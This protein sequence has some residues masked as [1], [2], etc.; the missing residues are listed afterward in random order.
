MKRL[1]LFLIFIVAPLAGGGYW[2][3]EQGLLDDYLG[4]KTSTS[5]TYRTAPIDRGDL[6]KMIAVTGAINPVS[7]VT[8][9]PQVS[10]EVAEVFVDFNQRVEPKQP[11]AQLRQD[12]FRLRIQQARYQTK[13]SASDVA[14]R[15]AAV[16]SAHSDL[17][18]AEASLAGA[19]HTR[20]NAKRRWSVAETTY[21]RATQLLKAGVLAQ[22]EV[23]KAKAALDDADAEVKAAEVKHRV[24]STT[25]EAKSARIDQLNEEV[26]ASLSREQLSKAQ[27]AEQEYNLAHTEITAP[28]QGVILNR[29]IYKGDVVSGGQKASEM[30]LIAENLSSMQLEMD[31]DESD[32]GRITTG[33]RVRFTVDAYPGR[34][35]QGEITQKRLN[36]EVVQSVVTYKVIAKVDNSDQTLLPGMTASAEIITDSRS[37]VLRVSASA[38][39]FKP[40]QEKSKPTAEDSPN[41]TPAETSGSQPPSRGGGGEGG[42]GRGGAF[43]Q[44]I[45]GI[46][47]DSSQRS[48]LRAAMRGINPEIQELRKSVLEGE[49]LERAISKL[50]NRTIMS[51]LTPE[52]VALFQKQRSEKE[53]E[54]QATLWT[55]DPAGGPKSHTVRVGLTTSKWAE[56]ISGPL[57]EGDA[58]IIG[59][60]RGSAK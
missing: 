29:M 59:I 13:A 3:W 6:S 14:A 41:S 11:I 19:N 45:Q 8:V 55:L 53:V 56:L 25:V 46:N 20:A 27:L 38:L 2:A 21:K 52:Q 35:F 7:T 30:F 28:I 58:V 50:R 49:S 36:P 22:A 10:G 40:K 60:A 31:I 9:I 26:S 42:G 57:G 48:Q 51:I 37:A 1:F 39:K 44:M 47:L 4:N 18:N 16:S 12:E 17:R 33:Q 32:I 43:G 34:S 23:D 5:T 15:R 24:A 54:R